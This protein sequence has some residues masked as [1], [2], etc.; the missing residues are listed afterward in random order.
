MSFPLRECKGGWRFGALVEY[1]SFLFLNLFSKLLEQTDYIYLFI[2]QGKKEFDQ[3]EA[4]NTG[5]IQSC[6]DVYQTRTLTKNGLNT[7]IQK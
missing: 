3:L 1:S 6:V 5:Y 2:R 4:C 7:V